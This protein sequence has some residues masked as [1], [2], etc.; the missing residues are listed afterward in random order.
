MSARSLSILLLYAACQRDS[1]SPADV[2]PI[3]TGPTWSVPLLTEPTTIYADPLSETS[4]EAAIPTAPGQVLWAAGGAVWLDDARQAKPT[5]V[6]D[7]PGAPMA[8]A[9][10]EDILLL[11]AAEALWVWDGNLWPSLLSDTIPSPVEDMHTD[12]AGQLWLRSADHLHRWDGRQLSAIALGDSR[13]VAVA[14]DGRLA[15]AGVVSWVGLDNGLAVALDQDDNAVEQAAFL[16]VWQLATDARGH[17][18]LNDGG[19]L[20]IRFPDA[21]EWVRVRL[22]AACTTIM[23]HPSAE[24]VWVA[25]T[26]GAYVGSADGLQPTSVGTEGWMAVDLH[27]RLLKRQDEALTRFSAG[28]SLSWLDRPERVE[29]T[30][31]L[32]LMPSTM[33]GVQS[34]DIWLDDVR[35][36]S[37]GPPW[38]VTVTP[39]DFTEGVPKLLDAAVTWADGTTA[40][41]SAELRGALGEVT[42]NN[43]IKGLYETSCAQ[44]HAGDAD[45]VLNTPERWQTLIDTIIAQVESGTM[46]LGED[47]LSIDDIDRIKAWMNTGFP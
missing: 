46:P 47:R 8:A 13:A 16:E 29:L 28:R 38:Q 39:G 12:T 1:D 7:V 15:E 22:G 5:R 11:S 27:G 19:G 17:A 6:E 35:V 31:Q 9:W 18:W 26:E 33:E 20:W 3:D 10:V 14:T 42:W 37:S 4:G 41:T 36:E 43:D 45:T 34:V 40:A 44:C 23:A 21:T 30:Q 25:T 2:P 24:T 32:T